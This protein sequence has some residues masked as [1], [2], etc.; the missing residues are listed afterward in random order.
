MNNST[1]ASHALEPGSG[2]TGVIA[3]TGARGYVGS[4]IVRELATHGHPLRVLTRTPAALPSALAAEQVVGDLA[5]AGV[6][7]RLLDGAHMLVHAGGV[8][9]AEDSAAFRLNVDAA[10]A[11]TEAVVDCAVGRVVVLSSG[12][13]FG[14][15]GGTVYE[16]TP[17]R[18]TNPYE[19]SKSQAEGKFA[20][21]LDSGVACFL[22]PTVVFGGNNP[23]NALLRLARRIQGRQHIPVGASACLNY[24][25]V[26]DVAHAVVRAITDPDTPRAVNLNCPAKM[27][28]LVSLLSE[29]V[30]VP[31]RIATIPATNRLQVAGKRI[32][33]FQNLAG[34]RLASLVDSTRIETRYPEWRFDQRN[35]DSILATGLDAMVADYRERGLL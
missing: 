32:P 25:P 2:H 26:T 23:T 15:P 11:L 22:R 28:A 4:Q 21:L 1:P 13:V 17:Q 9:R 19:V 7:R 24:V 6:L 29:S 8:V 10:A 5:D 20:P 18:P 31:A 16:D 3:I 34:G 14:Q 33:H 12:G 27:E 35:V 30:G